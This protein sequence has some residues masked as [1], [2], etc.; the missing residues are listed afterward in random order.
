MTYCTV[1]SPNKYIV[2]RRSMFASGALPIRWKNQ[3]LIRYVEKAKVQN[4]LDLLNDRRQDKAKFLNALPPVRVY[5]S[6]CVKE[7]KDISSEST[8]GSNKENSTDPKD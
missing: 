4:M 1:I 3:G 7:L 5:W 6:D 8:G 2:I